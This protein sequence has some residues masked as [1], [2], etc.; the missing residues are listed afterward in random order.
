[1]TQPPEEHKTLKM[2]H[3]R[4]MFKLDQAELLTIIRI[5]VS[6][7]GTLQAQLHVYKLTKQFEAERCERF[8]N[9]PIHD[10]LVDQLLTKIRKFAEKIHRLTSNKATTEIPL[11]TR[12]NRLKMNKASKCQTMH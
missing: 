11:P 12:A 3:Q 9:K 4:E 10:E 7:A 6:G 2:D 1:M 5:V 8:Q